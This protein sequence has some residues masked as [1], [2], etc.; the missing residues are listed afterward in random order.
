M[1]EKKNDRSW[2]VWCGVVWLVC[3]GVWVCCLCGILGMFY[4]EKSS[5]LFY[6]DGGSSPVC[7]LLT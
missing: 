4:F 6:D 7:L 1:A 5:V 3:V 2:I